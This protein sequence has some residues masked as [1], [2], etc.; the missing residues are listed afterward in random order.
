MG[1]FNPNIPI[2]IQLE[3]S[4]K[5]DIAAGRLAPGSKLPSVRELAEAKTVN[6]N[7]VQ[8][9]YQEL[10]RE[11]VTETRRGTGTY[12]VEK[13]DLVAGLKTQ[14]AEALISSF[15]VGMRELDLSDKEIS[16]M[17]EKYMNK[18]KR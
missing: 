14:L 12:V 4:I 5:Q 11:G 9:A 1:G 17:L 13:P 3:N 6:L 8:R 15:I 2:Y 18:E 10:E 16:A 7:T